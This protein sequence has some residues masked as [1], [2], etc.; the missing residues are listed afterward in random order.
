L[1]SHNL[2]AGPATGT[3]P[4]FKIRVVDA[5][6]GRGVPPV[7]LKTTSQ[8]RFY[9]GSA[10]VVA[11]LEP[12]LPGMANLRPGGRHGLSEGFKRIMRK[13]GLDLQTVKGWGK[14]MFSRRTFHALR[15][16]FTSALANQNV[17]SE[18]RMKPTG[19][20][21]AAMHQKYTHHEMDNLRTAIKKIPSLG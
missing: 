5:E 7:E 13:A 21:T 10:V 16:S 20:K 18:L 11:F 14:R 15:H 6:T 4:Y 19:H 17:S 2:L 1:L 8:Q 3:N 9:T 12:G